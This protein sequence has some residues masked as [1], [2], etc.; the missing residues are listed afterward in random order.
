MVWSLVEDDEDSEY[1]SSL[2]QSG[3]RFIDGILSGRTR[4]MDC[5]AE[6]ELGAAVD[7]LL[8]TRRLREL[9]GRLSLFDLA[10]PADV[11]MP[12]ARND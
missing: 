1:C 9:R 3:M 7:R 2:N 12:S 10:T 5:W 8:R 11:V 6:E 4:G